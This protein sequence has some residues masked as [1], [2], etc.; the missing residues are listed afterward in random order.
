MK[1]SYN[2]PVILTFA[3][4]SAGVLVGGAC[5]GGVIPHTFF[6]V[7]PSMQW[8]N[9]VDYFRLLS[10]VLGHHDI[11]HLAGNMTFILLLGPALEEKY[12]SINL[13]EMISITA[14]VTGLATVLLFSNGL[15]GASGIVFMMI[16]LNSYSNASEGK[17]PLTF[18][19]IAI[20]FMGK[21][22]L[23]ALQADQI[24]Q[25]AHLIG[26]VC[27]AAFGYSRVYD[28]NQPD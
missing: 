28:K 16:L 7:Y 24:S 1:F 11:S 13:F 4:I 21:E 10:H 6:T 2:S 26:G 14:V 20:L 5:T 15:M 3:I 12:G 25:A 17:I 22:V 8:S 18:V 9:P 23:Y 19:L 27:G